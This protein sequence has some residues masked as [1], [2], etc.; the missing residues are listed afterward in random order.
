MIKVEV[1]IQPI[2]GSINHIE[3]L[4][5]GNGTFVYLG[6]KWFDEYWIDYDKIDKKDD[7]GKPIKTSGGKIKKITD[8]KSYLEY[9]RELTDKINDLKI[10]SK[11]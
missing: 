4:I 3:S 2:I 11:K 8:L 10:G 1:A 5:K 6:E 7:G 9:R